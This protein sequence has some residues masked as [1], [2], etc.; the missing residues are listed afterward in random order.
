[1]LSTGPRRKGYRVE[2]Q[3]AH[4]HREIGVE[5]RRIPLSGAAEGYPGDLE[6][7]RGG[8]WLRGE[9]KARKAGKGFALLERWLGEHDLLFL[10]RN[11]KKPLVVMPWEVYQRLIQN[12]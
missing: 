8:R 2:N 12:E 10:K 5:C 1:M 6:I 4:L 11:R 9:V 3:L 7:R